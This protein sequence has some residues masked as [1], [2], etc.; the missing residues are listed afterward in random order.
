MKPKWYIHNFRNIYAEGC[1]AEV[2]VER[3]GTIYTVWVRAVCAPYVAETRCK[4]L[5]IEA[6]LEDTAGSILAAWEVLR[7]RAFAF[8]WPKD[9]DLEKINGTFG[10]VSLQDGASND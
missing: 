9:G 6:N 2:R 1:R 10:P 4:K 3:Q 5:L 8:E 7:G